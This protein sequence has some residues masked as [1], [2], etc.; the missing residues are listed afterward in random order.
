MA[1]G[2]VSPAFP[3][4]SREAVRAG[5]WSRQAVWG[6]AASKA[7]HLAALASLYAL[8]GANLVSYSPPSGEASI[9]LT[10]VLVQSTPP[11]ELEDAVELSVSDG[12][13]S[14]EASPFSTSL[15]T[16][17]AM[18]SDALGPGTLDMAQSP[19]GELPPPAAAS[20][21]R[22]E[23]EPQLAA[24][25]SDSHLPH[26]SPTS[27]PAYAI[28]PPAVAQAASLASA[29]SRADSLPAALFQPAPVYPPELERAGIE[30]IVVFR[31]KIA[32][33]GNVADAVIE[34]SSG[35][36]AMDRAALEAVRKWR[37][38]PARRFG[39]AVPIEVRKRFP[40]VIERRP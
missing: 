4:I 11:R 27:Q 9:E 21:S 35:F 26:R 32:A 19:S 23:A 25:S 2:E 13:S 15:A 34:Q 14:P 18:A 40:F 17:H 29:G 16:R 20:R 39:V 22:A 10:G 24:T 36:A 3:L 37:F 33:D 38:T 1:L 6:C 5:G 8:A 7:L 12:A 31:L 30:G 28:T